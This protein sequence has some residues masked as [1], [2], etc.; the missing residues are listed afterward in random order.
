MHIDPQV[1]IPMPITTVY[2]NNVGLV[3]TVSHVKCRPRFLVIPSIVGIDFAILDIKIGRN[4]QMMAP[5]EIPALAFAGDLDVS[6]IRGELVVGES[7]PFERVKLDHPI[8]V[9]FD[10]CDNQM[11]ICLT[12]RNMNAC[13]RNFMAVFYGELLE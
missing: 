8:P 9:K 7:L 12:V 2:G 6:E 5:G 1:L 11:V 4:S 13:A 10:D 3:R